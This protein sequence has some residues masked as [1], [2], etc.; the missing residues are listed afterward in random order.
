M[1]TSVEHAVSAPCKKAPRR[2][3]L[4]EKGVPHHDT[5][6]NRQVDTTVLSLLRGNIEVE[7]PMVNAVDAWIAP[8]LLPGGALQVRIL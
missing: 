7:C 3:G 8:V 6:L 2:C 4:P 1:A 5:R